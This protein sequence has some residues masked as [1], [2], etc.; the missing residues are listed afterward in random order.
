MNV[1]VS[2][3]ASN[4]YHST[5]F[6]CLNFCLNYFYTSHMWVC[7]FCVRIIIFAIIWIEWYGFDFHLLRFCFP[8]GRKGVVHNFRWVLW[9]FLNKFSRLHTDSVITFSRL[10]QKKFWKT[11]FNETTLCTGNGEKVD[12]KEQ[13]N[14]LA[15]KNCT[16]FCFVCL[17]QGLTRAKGN[18]KSKQNTCCRRRVLCNNHSKMGG[19][20]CV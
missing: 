12:K 20:G 16:C 14:I 15:V 11:L 19:V 7:T 4:G 1:C 10:L 6:F 8:T 2:V 13:G 17:A 5:S 3:C 18:K 9:F